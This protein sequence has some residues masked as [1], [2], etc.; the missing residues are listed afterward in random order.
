VVGS[1]VATRAAARRRGIRSRRETPELFHVV[2]A[3]L[4]GVTAVVIANVAE[5]RYW[6]LFVVAFAGATHA[7][8]RLVWRRHETRALRWPERPLDPRA[9]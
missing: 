1:V 7:I 8:E 9:R 5:Q 4:S 3:V 2:V 6:G